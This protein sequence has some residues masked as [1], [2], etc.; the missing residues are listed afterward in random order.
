MLFESVQQWQVGYPDP[1][2]VIPRLTDNQEQASNRIQLDGPLKSRLPCVDTE[3][4]L[5][6]FFLQTKS[7]MCLG[8]A[9]N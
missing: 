7:E 9:A 3:E 6:I 5:Y 4:E 1:N 2:E 8:H